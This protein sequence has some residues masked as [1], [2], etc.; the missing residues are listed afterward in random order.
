MSNSLRV[1]GHWVTQTGALLLV[2][3]SKAQIYEFP[4]HARKNIFVHI[5][6]TGVFYVFAKNANM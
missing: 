5:A 3:T 2:Q 1:V 6:D 4:M